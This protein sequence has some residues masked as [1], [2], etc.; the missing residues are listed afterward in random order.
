MSVKKLLILAAA[1]VVSTSALAGGASNYSAPAA[2]MSSED[3]VGLYVGVNAGW[4]QL[5]WKNQLGTPATSSWNNAASNGS[6]T[7]GADVGYS[8]NQYL[9]VEFGGFWLPTNAKYTGA[10]NLTL[11][12]WDLYLAG[13]GTVDLMDDVNVFGKLGLAY[14]HTNVSGT[15]PAT[16]DLASGTQGTWRPM[17]ATGLGYDF[18]QDWNVNAQ[19]ALILGRQSN[20]TT[21]SPNQNIYT[22]GVAYTFAM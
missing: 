8:F 2:S 4:D 19:Y 16:L 18:A 13:K 22:L 15:V 11:K 3:Q 10:S 17:F 5:D 7:M 14:T 1:G 6:F 12:T 9:A 20:G 21:Y